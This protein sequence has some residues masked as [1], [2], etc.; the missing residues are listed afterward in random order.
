[1][2]RAIASD[3]PR[4]SAPRPGY[5][6]GV[7]MRVMTRRAELGGELHQPERLAVALRV[8]HA[9]VAL[10]VLLGVAPLLVPDHHHRVPARRAHPPT[11]AGSSMY[12]PVAVELDEIGEDGAEII[13]GIRAPRV[14]G[15]HHPLQ[16]REIAVDVR[17]E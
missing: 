6:P 17:P 15:N 14:P 8:R 12:K 10:D 1:M 13:Q 5:A 11:I 2:F 3:W 9:E 16:R 7:S 4:S